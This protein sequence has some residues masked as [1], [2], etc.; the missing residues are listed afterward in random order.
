MSSSDDEAHIGSHVFYR[1]RLEWQDVIPIA[2]DEGPLPVVSIDYS[3]Q[4]KFVTYVIFLLRILTLI[5]RRLKCK[6]VL[7]K[8]IFVFLKLL[9]LRTFTIMLEG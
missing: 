2:S 6:I 5:Q 7:T 8:V 1:D 9:Q 4:C 3:D